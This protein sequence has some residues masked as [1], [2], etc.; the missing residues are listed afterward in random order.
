MQG[1][2]C[3]ITNKTNGVASSSNT[4]SPLSPPGELLVA[5]AIHTPGRVMTAPRTVLLKSLATNGARN[6]FGLEVPFGFVSREQT[7]SALTLLKPASTRTSQPALVH[8]Y[9]GE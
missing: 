8:Q 9:L 1:E 5:H 7:P 4:S 3:K 2:I 6:T